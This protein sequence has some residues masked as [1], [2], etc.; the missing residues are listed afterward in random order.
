MK[1]MKGTASRAVVAVLVVVALL[2]ALGGC[3]KGA[4]GYPA[5]EATAT[6]TIGQSC[7]VYMEQGC[8]QMTVSGT[9]TLL[10]ASGATLTVEDGWTFGTLTSVEFEGATANDYELTLTTADPTTPD[11]TVTLADASGTVMLSSLATNAPDAANSVTGA[12]N[13]LV[14]EGSSADTSETTL[15]ATNPTGDRAI[16]LPN[17]SG[18]VHVNEAT[19]ALIATSGTFGGGEGATGC[20]ISTAGVIQCDG[21][22]LVNTLTV[23]GTVTLAAGEIGATEIANI[24]RSLPVGIMNLYDCTT[25]A[26]ALIAWAEAPAGVLP[27]Y[28]GNSTDGLGA[29]LR[30]DATSSYVDTG[31]VCANILVPPDYV[32]GGAL[33]LEVAKT[34]ETA[35]ATEILDCQG[36]INGAALGTVGTVTIT[37]AAAQ[38][39]TCTPTLTALAAGNA[40]TLAIYVTSSGTRDDG[41]DILALQFQY[42]ATE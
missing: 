40:V 30:F 36:S 41:V 8:E 14:F 21:A 19:Q 42:T 26:G 9:G 29:V 16:V 20:T 10:V 1:S 39:V 33:T 6:Q 37:G 12:S 27:E 34:G 7:G 15:S 25:N 5:P 2:A 38:S 35:G 4:T 22:A 24:S 23:T 17:V 13:G 18:T 28:I 3:E 31:Y 11:K 32:S